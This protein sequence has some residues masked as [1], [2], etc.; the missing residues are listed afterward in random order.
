MI[1]G[2]LMFIGCSSEKKSVSPV[3]PVPRAIGVRKCTVP[4]LVPTIVPPLPLS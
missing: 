2:E 1:G 3:V 4:E